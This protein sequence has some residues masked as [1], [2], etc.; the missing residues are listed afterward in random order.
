MFFRRRATSFLVALAALCFLSLG[1]FVE[2]AR[3]AEAGARPEW[4]AAADPAETV[5]FTKSFQAEQGVERAALR[6][7]ADFCWASVQVDDTLV[8]TID[9]YCPTQDLDVTYALRRG[10]NRLKIMVLPKPGPTAIAVSLVIQGTDGKRTE[11]VSD[12]SWSAKPV[13]AIGK[14][15]ER[16]VVR[17]AVRPELWGLDRRDASVSPL[18]NYEQ[19]R[20]AKAGEH[21]PTQRF[22][23]PPGFEV[24][25]VRTAK[26]DEGSWIALAFDPQGRALVS[27]ED[28][29]F[30]RFTLDDERKSAVTTEAIAGEL[31]E[32]RGLLYAHDRLY[33][34][35]NK[36]KGLYSLE[37]DDRG[38]VRNQKLLREFPGEVG[39][40]RNDIALGRDGGIYAIMGDS[41]QQPTEEI[42]DRTSPLRESRRLMAAGKPQRKEAFVVHAD[43]DGKRWE[44]VCTGLRNPYG[45][46]VHPSGDLFTYDADNEFDMGTPWYRPT[47]IV[48]LAVGGDYGYRA[49]GDKRRPNFVDRPDNAQPLIDVGRGSPTAAMFG[50]DL[51]FPAEY[52]RAMFALDWTY[53]RVLAVHV[54][55][56]GCGYRASL[57]TF[58]QGRPLNVT[59]IAAGPDGAMYLI[60]GGRKTQSALY[61]VA[62]TGAKEATAEESAHERACAE[63]AAKRRAVL[64]D[65]NSADGAAVVAEASKLL[66]DPDPQ[67]RY[68]ARIALERLPAAKLE[69]DAADPVATSTAAMIDVHR[70]DAEDVGELLSQLLKTP[71]DELGLAE[72]LVLVS[73]YDQLF[74]LDADAVAAKRDDL[75]KQFAVC[76]PDPTDRD[77]WVT[78]YGDE[79]EFRRRLVFFLAKV[80]APNIVEHALPLFLSE[81][82]AD[83]I[84]ALSAL[85]T[86][87]NG[88]KLDARR[89]FFAALNDGGRF[90]GGQGMPGFLDQIRSDAAATLSAD[91]RKQ[92]AEVLALPKPVDEP[93]PP[94]RKP[95]KKW[96]LAELAQLAGD[97]KAG[98]DAERGAV[99]FRDALCSRCHRAGLSGPAVG[100]EL[101]F[102]ARRFSRNDILQSIVLPSASV[103][104]QYRTSE[105]ETTDGQMLVGR[106]VAEGDY[107]S[108][109]L[110]I[111]TD[112]LRP[113]QVREVDKKQITEHR[114]LP[115]SPMPEGLLDTFTADEIRDLLAFLERGAK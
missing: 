3:A 27:R 22:Y 79:S 54:A 74:A 37:I 75:A 26:P 31:R 20:I 57:E 114:L 58:L 70:A 88:W 82:Q 109:K 46:A 76:W 43:A 1:G 33:A 77:R 91:D 5:I 71:G 102:V 104:E 39:H 67:L 21:E 115:T 24:S 30:L 87:K 15:A 72:R 18:E 93:L 28:Q 84:A 107:R 35:V 53:G 105:I 90:I 44:F 29:G 99:V 101:T 9:A 51:K 6:F 73:L 42:V 8:L 36:S 100:P 65:L 62:Y 50:T 69:I 92:L 13:G 108:E 60:T 40:G 66:G 111:N 25:L 55:P 97:A 78:P 106:V 110:L 56:R 49:A 2:R 47:R 95:V 14:D 59:D 45:I 61:R 48:Q 86:V 103:A 4:I 17:G 7:A 64:D 83:R 94:K 34:N 85:S 113:S 98:G 12:E 38:R 19:W 112:A 16:L 81:S 32:C 80:N 63:F 96:T 23:A 68:A 41:V 52:R 89:M 10:A 11:I